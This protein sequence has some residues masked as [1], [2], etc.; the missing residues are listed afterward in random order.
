MKTNKAIA[1]LIFFFSFSIFSFAQVGIGTENPDASAIL[2]IESSNQGVL[3]TRVN[4]SSTSDTS[5]IASP[6]TGLLIYN[7]A[8][9]GFGSTAVTPGFYFYNGSTWVRLLNTGN[10]IS[11]TASITANTA[12]ITSNNISISAN[13]ANLSSYTTSI[14]ASITRIGNNSTNIASNTSSITANS[15]AIDNLTDNDTTYTAGTGLNLSD[16]EFS[17]DS[18]VVT[19]TYGGDLDVA[20][21]ITAPAFVGDGSGLTNLEISDSS[22]TSSKI[23]DGSITIIKLADDSVTSSKIIDDTILNED[24]SSSAA[25]AFS[26]LDIVKSNITDLGIPAEDTNTTYTAGTGLNLSDTEF[27]IDSNVVTSTY[28]GDIEV[29]GTI[30]ATSFSG[31]GSGLTGL[32]DTNTTY[33]AGTG[34]NLVGTELSI[35]SSV[36]TSTYTGNL[37]LTGDIT[38]TGNISTTGTISATA[39]TGD[40]SGLTGISTGVNSST[41]KDAYLN[42][43]IG[44]KMKSLTSSKTYWTD[45][46]DGTIYFDGYNGYANIAIGDSTLLFNTTGNYNIGLGFQALLNN[47]DGNNN[48]AMGEYA[49]AS[50]I[51]GSDNIAIGEE[52]LEDNTLGFDNIAIGEDTL[53]SNT[54]G[55]DNIAIGD[56]ALRDNTT[57]EFNIAI[58]NDA[59]DSLDEGDNNVSVGVD[60]LN[61]LASGN[62]NT[63]LGFEA[64]GYNEDS[65][66]NISY[67]SGVTLLGALTNS[68]DS[69]ISNSTAIGYGAV[70]TASN[71]IQLGNTD[72]NYVITSGTV[73]AAA[74]VGD[75]SGLT[76]ISTGVNSSTFKDAYLNVVIGTKMK[77]LTSSKT[78]WTDPDDGT[79]YFDGYNGYANIAIGDSTLLFN[80]T[81]N[82]NIGLG[83][84]ALLNNIDGNNNIAM[85]EYALASNI[86]GSD[87]IAIGEEAL[88]DNTL[89][90]DNI[91]IGEDTLKS[92][93]EGSDNIAIG[94][95]ALRDNTT[96]EFNI[97]IGN[98]ALDS[99]DEGD[100][101]VSVGVDALNDLASGNYNTALGFEAGGYNEDSDNNISYASGVT[102]LGALTNSTDSEISNSTAIGYGAVVTA[103]NNIQ[104]G[105][106][107]VNYVIT[108]GT[109]SAAAFVGD[110]S[111]LT[112]IQIFDSS[113]SSSKIADGSIT[114]SKLAG[115]SVTSSELA[116]DSVTSNKLADDSVTSSKLVGNSVT[117]STISNGTIVNED[118]SSSAAISFSKLNIAKSDIIGLGIPAADTNTTY[119]AGTGLSLSGTEFSINNNVVTSVY[120]YD[121]NLQEKLY[122]GEDLSV[123]GTTYLNDTY[124]NGYVVTSDKRLKTD[125]EDV[126]AASAQLAQLQPKKYKK[127]RSIESEEYTIEEMGFLAQDIQKLLPYLVKEGSDPDKLLSLDYNSFIALLVKGFQEHDQALE[128]VNDRLARIEAALENMK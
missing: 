6:A 19:S 51:E 119:I 75:G 8:T 91:A 115:D 65:D 102:L 15:T 76:G 41:F 20:G 96:G 2:Q 60:A 62:Y 10:I 11:N 70:V 54:E 116:D 125:I 34:L 105:N 101:N 120:A 67:A 26:K 95:D 55:S 99:L 40:G 43:V 69:E 93:T 61:D 80:T 1:L 106:T 27:S 68:T 14:T 47:I 127:K 3:I 90:F 84:Q 31:D 53:K 107:D 7:T 92:N 13:T 17:I 89:G 50:N 104:L 103:S 25:I 52:A 57:G 22:I 121:L 117:S 126:K 112:D 46:D 124:V 28:G 97:A 16:T 38:Q 87:N 4:L 23:A 98:D 79:I 77:S 122:V 33:T 66:N 29:A 123:L 73:S 109:V 81:G 74:F 36:V 48:I 63:A 83:F 12:S 24:V 30:T 37:A 9:A 45:P 114:T 58:G 85:G 49:L 100:N 35:D 110:G 118:V 5:T 86:E 94:D 44:T 64:G 39:F 111:G 21:T 113:I 18:S 56:D 108:S 32:T 88:E 59:L 82:Y 71:N 128:Q 78:Y 42:V 72:V